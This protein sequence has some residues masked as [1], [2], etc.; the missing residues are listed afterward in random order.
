MNFLAKQK[1]S[2]VLVEVFIIPP[3]CFTNLIELIL[4]ALV[5][6]EIVSFLLYWEK[7]IKTVKAQVFQYFQWFLRVSFSDCSVLGLASRNTALFAVSICMEL[8]S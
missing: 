5:R 3:K 7:I 1:S 6:K 4:Y 2:S 8:S